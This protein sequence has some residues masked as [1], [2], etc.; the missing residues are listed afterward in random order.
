TAFLNSPPAAPGVATA[1]RASG[2]LRRP[3][4]GSHRDQPG[5][6]LE[7]APEIEATPPTAPEVYNA[8]TQDGWQYDIII[9]DPPYAD[10]KI[11][12]TLKH[13]ARS[14]LLKPG[15]LVVIGHS[16]RVTLA[17]TFEK[18]AAHHNAV[19][20]TRIRFRRHGDS[21]F[22]IYLAGDPVSYGFGPQ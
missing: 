22:S 21:A 1:K 12:A 14:G 20:L 16:P 17:D 2:G 5:A 3:K 6:F 19:L 8:A 15:G 13:V 7:V 4:G 11:P 10:P 18:E 9:L